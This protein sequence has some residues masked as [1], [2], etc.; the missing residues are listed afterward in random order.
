MRKIDIVPFTGKY[1]DAVIKLTID[2]WT[3]VFSLT[4]NDVPQFVYDA[5]YPN[6]WEKRQKAEVAKLLENEPGNIWLAFSERSLAGFLGL[7]V[8]PEDQMGEIYIIAVSPRHQRQGVGQQLMAFAEGHIRSV[9]M[10]L[11]MVETIGDKGHEPARRAYESFGFERWPV[12]RYFK[13]L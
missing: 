13:Q 3:P 11:M 5:F 1:K 2:A 12:A 6:G 4:K 8:H 7:R 9:G 10:K